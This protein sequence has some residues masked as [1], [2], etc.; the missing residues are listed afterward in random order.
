MGINHGQAASKACGTCDLDYLKQARFQPIEAQSNS[1]FL[2]LLALI[3]AWPSVDQ[4]GRAEDKHL[5]NI[6]L[7]FD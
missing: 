5:G 2:K 4:E 7:H 3:L 1:V 6:L